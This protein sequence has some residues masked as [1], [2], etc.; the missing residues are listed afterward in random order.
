MR[1]GLSLLFGLLGRLATLGLGYLLFA[2]GI[3]LLYVF[4]TA[5][6]PRRSVET[7]GVVVQLRDYCVVEKADEHGRRTNET[8]FC[9]ELRK[10]LN[11]DPNRYDGASWRREPYV[12]LN[13]RGDDG[14]YQS[15]NGRAVDLGL[16]ADVKVGERVRFMVQTKK[17]TWQQWRADWYD[18]LPFLVLMFGALVA[19]AVLWS[20]GGGWR[21]M[22]R[23]T[24]RDHGG[25]LAKAHVVWLAIGFIAWALKWVWSRV[26]TTRFAQ[27]ATRLLRNGARSSSR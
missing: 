19:S 20:R 10:K 13:Y 7:E 22:D 16:S 1:R 9:E 14:Q 18:A 5:E 2:F 12:S 15:R 23:Q 21:V 3:V 27:A 17:R 26:E 4:L 8:G 6:T 24:R 25:T 11:W